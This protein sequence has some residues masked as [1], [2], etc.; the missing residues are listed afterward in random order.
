MYIGGVSNLEEDRSVSVGRRLEKAVKE[1]FD[2]TD[3][4]PA[5][6]NCVRIGRL[7]SERAL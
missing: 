3:G 6:V 5:V 1:I 4:A 2:S 7:K